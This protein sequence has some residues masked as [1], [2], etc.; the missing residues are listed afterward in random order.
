MRLVR[1]RVVGEAG[2]MLSL[3]G[4]RVRVGGLI[5]PL[6]VAREGEGE[7]VPEKEWAMGV[8]EKEGGELGEGVGE[9]T[10]EEEEEGW[11]EGARAEGARAVEGE[12]G[13]GKEGEEDWD[14]GED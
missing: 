3:P 4:V 5:L 9:V 8:G 12:G 13:R 7:E 10:E 2:L 1:G 14:V 6:S 11:E